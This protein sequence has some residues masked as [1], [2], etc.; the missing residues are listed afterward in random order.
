ML[1]GFEPL[2]DGRTR[3]LIIG[4]MPGA[5]SLA[6]GEYY[7]YRYNAFW[8]IISEIS[9]EKTDCYEDKKKALKKISGG[10]WDSLRSCERQGSLD[11]A[12]R[13][14]VPNDFESLL[15]G[16]PS[17]CRLFFNGSAAFRYFRKY[18]KQLLLKYAYTVLPSTSPA[19]AKM[20]FAE[21]LAVWR[22][23][24]SVEF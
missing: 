23:E 4:T 5:A 22:K 2:I 9:G 1:A 8:R 7:A 6:A 24:L 14:E 12:I 17:V 16:H 18:H 3:F 11:S 19:N 15:R 10:L 21:K 20:P 13:C